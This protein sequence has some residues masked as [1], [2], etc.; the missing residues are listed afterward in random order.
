M[1]ISVLKK[2]VGIGF[3][4]AII[5]ISYAERGM[6]RTIHNYSTQPWTFQF[7]DIYPDS[8]VDFIGLNCHAGQPCTVPPNE[9]VNI[10]YRWYCKGKIQITDV[11]GVSKF[12]N[13]KCGK[14]YAG[15]EQ[16][17]LGELP[18][19]IH[20]GNTGSVSMNERFAGD[21]S[22]DAGNVW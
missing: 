19:I 3:L 20:Q 16:G 1:I 14:R 4:V 11:S 7:F 8:V 18:R 15:I 21:I 6:I 2:M 9:S 10:I 5:P 22:V 17:E 12:F 13:Y